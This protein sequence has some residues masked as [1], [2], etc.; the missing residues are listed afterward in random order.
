MPPDWLLLDATPLAAM[1][2]ISPATGPATG[3]PTLSD[4]H[5]VEADP[6]LGRQIIE[7]NR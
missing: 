2:L 7:E 5:A 1:R 6:I 3:P 4:V